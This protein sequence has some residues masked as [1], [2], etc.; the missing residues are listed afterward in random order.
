MSASVVLTV[1]VLECGCQY[2]LEKVHA[3]KPPKSSTNATGALLV[4]TLVLELWDLERTVPQSCGTSIGDVG[5]KG[6]FLMSLE[7]NVGGELGL[8]HQQP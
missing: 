8:W 2:G 6:T 4:A 1:G 7:V 5:H 3:L